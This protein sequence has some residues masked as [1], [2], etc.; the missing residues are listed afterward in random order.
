M[1][2]YT[3]R[4]GVLSVGCDEV[5]RFPAGLIGLEDCQQWTLA[6]DQNVA[7]ICW[8]QC[9]TAPEIALAVVNPRRYVP[10]YR[11]RVTRRAVSPLN[12]EDRSQ[13]AVLAILARDEHGVS[14]NLKAPLVINVF[15]RLGAQTITNDNQPVR[16]PV[17]IESRQWRRS[18]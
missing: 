3:T 10:H 12:L 5:V 6:A 16:L 17:I 14:V 9:V 18:A 8:L 15:R 13:A 1:N 4:F 7:G 2:V 11:L